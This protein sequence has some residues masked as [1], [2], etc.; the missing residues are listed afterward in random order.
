MKLV[1][2]LMWISTKT[3]PNLRNS[4]EMNRKFSHKVDLTNICL[5]EQVYCNV[6]QKVNLINIC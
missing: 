2:G 3:D 4:N 6:Y 5:V 1:V